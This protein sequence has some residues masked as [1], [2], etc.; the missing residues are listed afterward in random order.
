MKWCD[1]CQHFETVTET[2]KNPCMKGIKMKFR[3]GRNDYTGDK[4]GFYRPGCEH[5]SERVQE[6]TVM[7]MSRVTTID[8]K[9]R[10]N[11]LEG[12]GGK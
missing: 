12:G 1:D 10:V 8:F 5:W 9:K 6:E 2:R 4:T 7:D 11:A 3:T